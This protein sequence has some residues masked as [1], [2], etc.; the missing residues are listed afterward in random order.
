MHM[1]FIEQTLKGG[2]KMHEVVTGRAGAQVGDWTQD[3]ELIMTKSL[4]ASGS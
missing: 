1:I 3:G 2:R 4:C